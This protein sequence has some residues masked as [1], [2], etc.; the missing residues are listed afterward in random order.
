MVQVAV[1]FC[2]DPPPR[3]LAWQWGS[4]SLEE[5]QFR[6]RFTALK[7]EPG[8]KKVC[9]LVGRNCELYHGKCEVKPK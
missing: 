1:S 8:H 4:L 2:S 5:G 7:A 6:G 9:Y 3:R